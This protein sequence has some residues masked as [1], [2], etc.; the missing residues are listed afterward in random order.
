[1]THSPVRAAVRLSLFLAATFALLIPYLV[2]FPLGRR[3][4]CMFAKLFYLASN[5]LTGLRVTVLGK[6]AGPGTLYAANHASYLDIPVLC[7]VTDGV[8]VAKA[9]V[10]GWPLFGF[11]AAIG[12]TIFVSRQRAGV[13]RERLAIAGRLAD[14]EAVFLFPEGSSSDG[15][16]VMP[17]RT[18][19]MTAAAMDPELDVLVQPVTIAYGPD[20]D[21]TV[22]D[23]Y[24]WYGD[25]DLAPH[26]L[27][28]FGTKQRLAVEVRFHAPRHAH[29]F[30]H[31]R[32]LADWA[33]ANVA[34][35]LARSL[36][37]ETPNG[38]TDAAA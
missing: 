20:A 27:K 14:G 24:A 17:F 19:L 4:R 2:C 1:M 36:G 35:G 13:T 25:M 21:Q 6:P 28:L 3:A 9:E 22:R 26:L 32:Q 16:R 31:R 23:R 18:A 11:L 29:D 34:D 10:R 8:F 12:R 7:A 38:E 15:A 30:P 33:Q 5:R 37:F